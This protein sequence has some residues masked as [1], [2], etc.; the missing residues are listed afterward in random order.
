MSVHGDKSSIAASWGTAAAA[1][2]SSRKSKST[3]VSDS[4]NTVT[5]QD[6][7]ETVRYHELVSM[8][9]MG[10]EVAASDIELEE[11]SEKAKEDEDDNE[12][13]K[14]DVEKENGEGTNEEEEDKRGVWTAA[15]RLS[16]KE[17]KD[18]HM[19]EIMGGGGGDGGDGSMSS[20]D[21]MGDDTSI[22]NITDCL[23]CL[24]DVSYATSVTYC[25]KTSSTVKLHSSR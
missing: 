21:G 6:A 12:E 22:A 23:D 5:V 9:G 14:E 10:E 20:D 17:G 2:H 18:I 13:E 19:G 11:H 3:A 4:G 15:Q 24:G 25:N 7:P 1:G 8:Y 16:G